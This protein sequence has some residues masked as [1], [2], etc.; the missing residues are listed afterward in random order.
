[1]GVQSTVPITIAN[2]NVTIYYITNKL[3]PQVDTTGW[4]AK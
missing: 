4:L 3:L 2:D 1:M